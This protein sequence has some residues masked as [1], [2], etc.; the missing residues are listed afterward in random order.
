VVKDGTITMHSSVQHFSDL[1]AE[2]LFTRL[3]NLYM[4]ALQKVSALLYF[5]RKWKE[6]EEWRGIAG[7]HA[8]SQQDKPVDLAVIV[9]VATKR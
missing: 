4:R 8:T 2:I 3:F 1:K 7:C 6:L 5:Q 9:R